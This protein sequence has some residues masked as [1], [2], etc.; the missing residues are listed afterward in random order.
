MR[1]IRTVIVDDEPPARRRIAEL[2]AR[3][4]DM[5]IEGEFGRGTD[6]LEAM[7]DS[8]PDLL[9]LDVQMPE[10]DGFAVLD[11]I[12]MAAERPPVTIFVTAYD[13][14]ALKAFEVRALDYLLK[15]FSDERFESALER[16]RERILARK[17]EALGE[18]LLALVET[19]EPPKTPTPFLDRIVVKTASR[20]RFVDV[21]DID[22]I[23]A[24]GVY[25]T[26]HEGSSEHLL[27]DSLSA[28]EA[29][30]D[31]TR[32]AR[33]HR[34]AIVSLDRVRELRH[35]ERGNYRVVL[36]DGTSLRLSRRYRES[37]ERRMR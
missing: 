20:I 13:T 12:A 5:V 25:V 36:R 14:Y 37:F 17:K 24:A 15:P 34:S 1:R 11:R 28:I 21:G 23:E 30:L 2:L 10:L 18:K 35:D 32:F 26:I 4:P 16:A 7:G 22:W 33:I 8:V 19:D 3:E 27:R 6:A 31:P 9:F 29:R